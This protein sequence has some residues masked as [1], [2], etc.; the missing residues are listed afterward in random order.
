VLIV[1]D[2]Q[3]ADHEKYYSA[4]CDSNGVLYDTYS[5]QTSGSPSADT[6]RH[7][8]VVV[9][10]TGNDSITTLT[11]TDEA[12]LAAYFG[13]GG[14]LLL[15]GQHVAQDLSDRQFLADY[16]RCRLAE[17][18]TGKPFVV[19][20][21]GD[22]IMQGDT[23]CLG[24]AGGANNARGQDGILVT[25]GGMGCGF[26]KDYGDTTVQAVVRY[27]GTY[28]LVFFSCPFEAIDHSTARYVQKW[29][30]LKRILT[31]FGERVPRLEE[32]SQP[33]ATRT[34]QGPA[35]DCPT[36]VGGHASAWFTAP[37][38]GTVRFSVFSASGR[39]ISEQ[40]APAHKGDRLRFSVDAGQM[41]AGVY[42]V[43][44]AAPGGQAVRKVAVLK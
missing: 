34:S 18:S 19:G 15:S 42:F 31:W 37:L 1:D 36:I 39:L 4:A 2:D 33:A 7:Y 28:R 25:N 10:F 29:T 12:S 21:T 16:L 6:L 32:R 26:Y 40:T 41:C 43:Q 3:G 8:A 5:V 11:A 14:S 9:W 13:S 20:L 24:G 22:P 23:A 17:D 44:L 35:L 27:A 38:S 30:L